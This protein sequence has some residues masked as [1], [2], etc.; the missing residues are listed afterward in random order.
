[1]FFDEFH[2]GDLRPVRIWVSGRSRRKDLSWLADGSCRRLNRPG[3]PPGRP[4]PQDV[5]AEMPDGGIGDLK[6][7]PLAQNG[8]DGVVRGA[9]A[10]EFSNELSVRMKS[11]VALGPL[12]AEARDQFRR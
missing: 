6:A 5:A 4:L 10:P 1:L 11:G 8:D 3:S 12:R 9:I 2:L 7:V